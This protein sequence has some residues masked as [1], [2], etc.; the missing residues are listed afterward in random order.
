MTDE[1]GPSVRLTI[2]VSPEVRDELYKMCD[3]VGIKPSFVFPVAL[4]VG[5]RT[6]VQDYSLDTT[7]ELWNAAKVINAPGRRPKKRG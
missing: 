6:L 2:R 3:A 1:F 4:M 5:M 7:T